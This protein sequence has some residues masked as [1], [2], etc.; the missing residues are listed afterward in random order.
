MAFLIGLWA[1][2]VY[3]WCIRADGHSATY[4]RSTGAVGNK[5]NWMSGLSGTLPISEVS[6]PGTHDTMSDVPGHDIANCQTMY[7]RPQLDS[8]IRALDIRLKLIE[9]GELWTY[10]GSVK[11]HENF[12][13]VLDEVIDFLND[14]PSEFVIMRVKAE[15]DDYD[16]PAFRSAIRARYDMSEYSGH[17]IRR[18]MGCVGSNPVCSDI[19]T[20]ADV[21]GKIVLIR[22]YEGTDSQDGPW[23]EDCSVAQN[24]WKL[25]S[26][27]DLYDKWTKIKNF[28]IETD[29]Q[30]DSNSITSF[31]INWLSAST[32]SF[33]YFV[34]SGHSSPQE[35][36]PRLYTGHL[37]SQSASDRLW[38]DFPRRACTWWFWDG[39]LCSVD[40]EGTNR[41]FYDHVLGSSSFKFTGIVMM[42]FPGE[43]LITRIILKNGYNLDQVSWLGWSPG[44]GLQECEG[45]CDNNDDCS[46]DLQCFHDGIPPGCEGA[47]E[48]SAADYCYDPDEN[49]L[50]Q[51]SW[52]G[53]SPASGLQ[54]CEGDCDSDNDCSDGLQCFH[55]GIPL[56]CYG[57]A[58]HPSSDYCYDPSSSA[59]SVIARPQHLDEDY[60]RRVI[61]LD[62]PELD[63]EPF[64]FEF[65]VGTHW[66]VF[67]SVWQPVMALA[68]LI[69]SVVSMVAVCVH[70]KR[71]QREYVTVKYMDSELGSDAEIEAQ[72]I[73]N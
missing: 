33:P 48:N 28:A 15:D 37:S 12:E 47:A 2:S 17:L 10:H 44:S 42:D 36:A 73:N 64:A 72:P 65:R 45:D 1:I 46:G 69:L 3:V 11:L 22:D 34:A 55:N 58:Y 14:N 68:I 6:I 51:V 35:D 41:L 38:P 8:G 4:S 70:F 9:G 30:W 66:I 60:D 49:N 54:K 40:F 56:G 31:H 52:L 23:I 7:L 57:A 19:P 16:K 53:W 29:K 27:W 39:E 67:Q 18:G 32:G 61:N 50:D 5:P 26:N 59:K 25:N 62:D 71:G 63:P 13:T 43:G 24:E 21:R 20:V